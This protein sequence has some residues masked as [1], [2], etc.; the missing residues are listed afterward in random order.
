MSDLRSLLIRVIL[1][2]LLAVSPPLMINVSLGLGSP[3]YADDD[4]NDDDGGDDDDDD[5]D[6]GNAPRRVFTDDDDDDD[7]IGAPAV[8]VPQ[9]D[10][11]PDEIIVAG[12]SGPDLNQLLFEGYALLA[13]L[14]STPVLSRLRIPPNVPIDAARARVRLLGSGASADFNHYYRTSQSGC[15][16]PE[17]PALELIGYPVDRIC[18]RTD[19]RIGMVDTGI[20]DTHEVFAERRLTVHRISDIAQDPSRAIHGTAVAAI[21]IGAPESRSPGLLPDATLL[22]VDAFYRSGADERA[23]AF[24]IAAGID[25]LRARDISVLNLSLAGPS[26]TELEQ[27]INRIAAEDVLV[28]A[29]VGNAGPRSAPAYPAAYPTTLAVTAVDAQ[30]TIYRR[31][32]QGNHVNL[33]APG[34]NIWTAASVS[35]ARWRTGTS[36]AAPFATAAAALVRFSWPDFTASQVGDYLIRGARDAGDPGF[37]PVFGAGILQLNN[38]CGD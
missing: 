16:R 23:D 28:I 1:L 19:I 11:A 9:L 36:F 4:D 32:G 13:Q 24:S 33:A 27:A 10:F 25:W 5:D 17:C 30:G 26:N 35:G 21:L 2:V 12:L 38:R 37:D 18:A 14:G 31:A 8:T 7:G 6:G 34:V 15:E 3:A 22:A 29:A 20:N